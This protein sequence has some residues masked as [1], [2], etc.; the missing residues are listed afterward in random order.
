LVE[1]LRDPTVC[2]W[3]GSHSSPQANPSQRPL[4]PHTRVWGP[5][6]A[7]YVGWRSPATMCGGSGIQQGLWEVL[8]RRVPHVP[9]P[10]P[11]QPAACSSPPLRPPVAP[12]VPARQGDEGAVPHRSMFK[13]KQDGL[14]ARTTWGHKGTAIQCLIQI[15]T[16][17]PIFPS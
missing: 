3:L 5:T 9:V 12:A 7:S 4:T 6:T 8:A 15:Q 14:H 1:R 2:T 10:A 17:G 13:K 11:S 16:P